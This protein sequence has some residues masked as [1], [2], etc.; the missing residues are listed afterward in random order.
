MP[1]ARLPAAFDGFTIAQLSDFHYDPV[2]S[3]VPIRRGIEIVNRLNPDLVV[4]TGDF[5]TVSVFAFQ[6]DRES[7]KVAEPCAKLLS[8]LRPR[9][10]SLAVLGNH[11]VHSDPEFVTEA[12]QSHGIQVLCNSS[13]PIDREGSR[14]W[15]CGL[16]SVD[17][18]PDM[19]RMLYGVPKTE[20][21]IVLVHEPDFVDV[22]SNY[23]VDLQ[24]SGHSHGGQI[25]LPGIG[26]PWLPRHARKYPRG[27]YTV[28]DLP[29]YT[30]IGLGTIRAP[31]RLNCTP[32]VT[33]F[34]L[35]S[36]QPQ[37]QSSPSAGT[38]GGKA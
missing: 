9:L 21:V 15:F 13:R 36:A 38:T 1:L 18:D 16:D 12:L 22:A 8:E 11:D 33:L 35:R 7:A 24:L 10:G 30:N 25:W 34:T 31:V 26:A 3:A 17:R 6:D 28:R 19:E 2:F 4:L 20:A 29:L 23:A 14:L 32:E 27:R 5:V 37:G